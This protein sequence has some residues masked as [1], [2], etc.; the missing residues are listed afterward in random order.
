M[1]QQN[2]SLKERK[3]NQNCKAH[4]HDATLLAV[5]SIHFLISI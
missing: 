1:A 2:E 3:I 5:N 4:N